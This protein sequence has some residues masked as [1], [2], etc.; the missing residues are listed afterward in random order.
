MA[1]G[2]YQRWLEPDG[3]LLLEAWARDGMTDVQIAKKCGITTTTLYDWKNKYAIISEAL[4]KGKEVVDVGVE[5]ALL[6]RALG[7]EYQEVMVEES[8]DGY[9]RRTTTKSM[10]PDVTAII[11]WLKNRKR[12]VWRDKPIEEIDAAQLQKIEKLLGGVPSAI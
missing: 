2:K 12:D 1:I 10:P 9:K 6:K 11:Y 7:Y 8:E 4:K 3:L 5:N